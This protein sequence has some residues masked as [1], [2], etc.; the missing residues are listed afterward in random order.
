MSSGIFLFLME[1]LHTTIERDESAFKGTSVHPVKTAHLPQCLLLFTP[2]AGFP[3]SHRTCGE[4]GA[5]TINPRPDTGTTQRLTMLTCEKD[6]VFDPG[7]NTSD[8]VA[9]RRG[10]DNRRRGNYGGS[11]TGATRRQLLA[12]CVFFAIL[13]QHNVKATI[14]LFGEIKNKFAFPFRMSTFSNVDRIPLVGR[15]PLDKCWILGTVLQGR[16]H[17]LLYEWEE[18]RALTAYRGNAPKP[19]MLQHSIKALCPTLSHTD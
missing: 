13:V 11:V 19:A 5:S 12:R 14:H 7:V 3:G 4:S 10:V 6:N 1:P 8:L 9:P 16:C 18:E 15:F 2:A 17:L